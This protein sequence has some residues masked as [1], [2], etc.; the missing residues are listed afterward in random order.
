MT[1][2]GEHVSGYHHKNRN[3]K[4]VELPYG[5]GCE[6]CKNCFVCPLPDC[7]WNGNYPKKVK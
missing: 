3:G 7:T 6:K 1:L 4:H 5:D 2:K